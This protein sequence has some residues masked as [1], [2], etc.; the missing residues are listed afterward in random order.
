M[1]L[2]TETMILANL[3]NNEEFARKTLPFLLADYF[4]D[5]GNK[6]TYIRVVDHYAKYNKAPTK[7]EISICLDNENIHE[8][9]Y[10]DI[11]NTLGHVYKKPD[12]VDIDWLL[13]TTEKFCQTRAIHNAIMESIHIIDGEDKNRDTGA[14]PDLLKSALGVSFDRSIGHTYIDDWESR[15]DSYSRVEEKVGFDID[16]LNLITGGGFS[17]K[18]LN[19]FLGGTGVGKTLVMCHLAA[20]NLFQGKN[21]LY[22]TMEMSE[23]KIAERIDANLLDERIQDLK[24]LPKKIYEKRIDKLRKK[25]LGNLIIKEYPTS[26]VGAGHFR[27]LLSELGLKK[28]FKPDIIYIDYLNLCVSM[29]YKNNGNINSYN[30]VKSVAEELR[31]LAVEFKVPL[32][33]ATQT[34]REGYGSSNP[35]LTN[36]SEC[37]FV[38]E[39]VT[40]VDGTTKKIGDVRLGDQITAQDGYKTVMLVHHKKVKPC[41]QITTKSGK[42]I[43]VS[44]DHVFPTA[45]GRVAIKDGLGVGDKLNTLA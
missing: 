30:Y 42:K 7:T 15:F 16:R 23:E 26:S 35:D 24:G 1:H 34:N 36:T 2:E 27:H 5:R 33:T 20:T 22:I 8:K 45:R 31:G 10:E 25:T 29:R 13:N 11:Q 40:L 37:I 32:V 14:I 9:V 4:E 17:K 28:N 38:D 44:E 12:D 3:V 6:E 19:V 41:Y 39:E 18:T 21:V 43:I